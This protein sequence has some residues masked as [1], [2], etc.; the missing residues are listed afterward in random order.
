MHKMSR[1]KH[2]HRIRR[3]FYGTQEAIYERGEILRRNNSAL[4]FPFRVNAL[5]DKA[6]GLEWVK[7]R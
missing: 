7:K 6:T 3:I 2:F 5:S 4:P 1:F